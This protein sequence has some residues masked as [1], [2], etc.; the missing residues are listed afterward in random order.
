MNE[1]QYSQSV[2]NKWRYAPR[3]LL[4]N[5]AEHGMLRTAARQLKQRERIERLL[6]ELVPPDWTRLISVVGVAQ[7]TVTLA[8]TDMAVTEGLRRRADKLSKQFSRLAP[9]VKRLR[10]ALAGDSK[11]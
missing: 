6:E 10:V 8:S 11:E 9:G 2:R 7:G 1:M 5:G 3:T 4:S